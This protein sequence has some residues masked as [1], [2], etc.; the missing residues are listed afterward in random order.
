MYA[1]CLL[2]MLFYMF[3]AITAEVTAIAKLVTLLA[4][5]PLW[6]TASIVL[7]ATVVYTFYGGLRA[8]IFTDQVQ[9][10]IIIPLLLALCVFGWQATEIGR[11]SC[12]ESV[13]V[14]VCGLLR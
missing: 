6:V 4:P 12:R 8:S 9:I 5:I 14:A 10:F 7:L 2:I 11:A 3:I 1:L 13:S